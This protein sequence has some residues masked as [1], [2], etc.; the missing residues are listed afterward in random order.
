[1]HISDLEMYDLLKER[2]S[3]KEAREFVSY[4]ETKV[5]DKF[6]EAKSIFATKED[7]F[8]LELKIEQ[9]KSESLKWMFLFVLTS[10]LAV[11]GTILSVMKMG[12]WGSGN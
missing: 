4:I 1:M 7:I 6:T 12:G 3:E 10:T 9:T 5:E 8:K 11:I 2:M